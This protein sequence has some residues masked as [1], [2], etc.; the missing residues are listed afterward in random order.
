MYIKKE[1]K[2]LNSAHPDR[3]T[4]TM[5]GSWHLHQTAWHHPDFSCSHECIFFS[6]TCILYMHSKVSQPPSTS[7]HAWCHVWACFGRSYIWKPPVT[8]Q[9]ISLM[10][11]CRER[12]SLPLQSCLRSVLRLFALHRDRQ[13]ATLSVDCT[14]DVHWWCH[15]LNPPLF[16]D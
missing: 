5:V 12:A 8:S 7:L 4:L 14:K 11:P 2:D 9:A 13:P 10:C 15:D 6:K 1:W 16:R 3:F